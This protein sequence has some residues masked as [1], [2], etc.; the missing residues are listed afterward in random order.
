MLWSLDLIGPLEVPVLDLA[1][2]AHEKYWD[3]QPG[4][5][6]GLLGKVVTMTI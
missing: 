1:V 2:T 3:V 6:G 5:Q 4:S